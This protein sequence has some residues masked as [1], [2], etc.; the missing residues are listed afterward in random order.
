MLTI[1]RVATVVS[2]YQEEGGEK[3]NAAVAVEGEE[4]KGCGRNCLGKCCLPSS[5]LPLYTFKVGGE[6]CAEESIFSQAPETS[7]LRNLLLGQWENRMNRGLFRYDVTTCKTKVIPGDYGFIAQLNE[8]RHLKKRL[9]EFR[10]DQVLQDFNEKKFNFTKVGQE[11]VLF[12]F[13]QSEDCYSHFFPSAPAIFKPSSLNVVAINVSP[14]EYGHV[15]LVPRILDCLPQRIDH[16][17]FFLAL[18][19]AREAADPFFRVGYNSLGAF[20]TI[21]HL[22]FQAYYLD[23]L[24]PVEKVPS[25][26]VMTS[27]SVQRNVVVSRLLKFPVRSLVFEG[28]DTLRDLSNAV[29]NSCIR[30]QHNNIPFNVLISDCGKRVFL[31]PQC[32]A[33]KQA[34]GEVSQELLETQVNPAVWEISGH[35]VLKRREDFENASE[36]YAW[37]LLAEVS[38]SEES[39]QEVKAHISEAAGLHEID[40][41]A[42]NLHQNEEAVPTSS[43]P[44]ATSHL[45]Q[46]CLVVKGGA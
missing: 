40:T 10:V 3:D 32:Y 43:V 36:D 18:S 33:K 12:I 46:D 45:H 6:D 17:S 1:K 19:L 11:E 38:L 30:L 34:Q 44:T 5:D 14:I 37:R 16:T 31:F 9:T 4:A 2:N 8:G 27:A 25:L 13:E 21:N 42:Y 26:R 20:A 15:L 23:S 24:F 29:A 22:H 35:I 39:F 28:G 7:F 41:E